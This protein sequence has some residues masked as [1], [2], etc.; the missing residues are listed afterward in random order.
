MDPGKEL[1]A[2][3]ARKIFR[4]VVMVD[5]VTNDI[6]LRDVKN[7]KW[8][9]IPPYSKNTDTAYSLIEYFSRKGFF[10]VVNSSFNNNRTDWVVTFYSS[11]QKPIV[12]SI[13][14]TAAHAI[15]LAALE[16][17]AIIEK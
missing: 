9:A 1:D 12:Q 3:I 8:M 16:L 10:A 11:D 6:M 5:S 7:K 2:E 4:L 17:N 15:C 14:K 13:G